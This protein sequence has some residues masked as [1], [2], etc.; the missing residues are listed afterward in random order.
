MTTEPNQTTT[1]ADVAKQLDD[2]KKLI[3]LPIV[4]FF[5]AVSAYGFKMALGW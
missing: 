4:L 3:G 1:N 5:L 2:I